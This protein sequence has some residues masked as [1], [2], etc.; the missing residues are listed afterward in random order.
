MKVRKL[1]EPYWAADVDAWGLRKRIDTYLAVPASQPASQLVLDLGSSVSMKL[2]LIPK[3]EFTMG[4]PPDPS[5]S[6]GVL[7]AGNQH[8]ET[9]AQPFYMG[10]YSVTQAQW[11][12]IMGMPPPTKCMSQRP[13]GEIM[14]GTIT[15]QPT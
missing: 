2:L 11:K 4:S 10:V 14:S 3:G 13:V 7:R 12:A 6:N 8:K 15:P 5:D 1:Y 9:I